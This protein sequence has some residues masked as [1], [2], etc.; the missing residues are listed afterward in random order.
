MS[1][2][3]RLRAEGVKCRVDESAKL[4]KSN[5]STTPDLYTSTHKL[6]TRDDL[7]IA[8]LTRLSFR[9]ERTTRLSFRTESR[10]VNKR[11]QSSLEVMLSPNLEVR[12]RNLSR[13]KRVRALHYPQYNEL[14]SSST[15]R[16]ELNHEKINI[17]L[18]TVNADNLVTRRSELL[19]ILRDEI[20]SIQIPGQLSRF[21]KANLSMVE[22]CSTPQSWSSSSDLCTTFNQ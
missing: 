16:V 12:R 2:F 19:T 1:R 7:M 10:S 3:C 8:S 11:P 21:R 9:N 5:L 13:G 17:P 15:I 6:Q 20:V 18:S 4:E 22:S 14:S